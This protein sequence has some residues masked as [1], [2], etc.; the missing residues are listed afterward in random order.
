M[1]NYLNLDLKLHPKKAMAEIRVGAHNLE[2]EQGRKNKKRSV[3]VNE[4]FGRNCKTMMEGE[5]H[6]IS[7]YPIYEPLRSF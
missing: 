5:V 1:A 6:F 2:I 4:R 3:P 7:D